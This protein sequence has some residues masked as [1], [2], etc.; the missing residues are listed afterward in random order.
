MTRLHGDDPP[1]EH[2]AEFYQRV[3]EQVE[4]VW[5]RCL[6]IGLNVV[7]DFGFW[8]RR[9][10]DVVRARIAAIGAQARL[11]RLTCSE[12]AY[13]SPETHSKSSRA[14]SNPLIAMRIV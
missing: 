3:C 12:A 2:Y 14:V 6:E 11:Y 1:V 4:K 13:P 10:R 8:T 7:L 9:E 5:P